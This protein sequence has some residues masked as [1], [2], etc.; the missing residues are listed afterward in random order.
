MI[1]LTRDAPDLPKED[2]LKLKKAFQRV[3]DRW[4][5]INPKDLFDIKLGQIWNLEVRLMLECQ[6]MNRGFYVVSDEA[7]FHATKIKYPDAL[8][9][10]LLQ[11]YR[12]WNGL[13]DETYTMTV[14]PKVMMIMSSMP[15][16]KVTDTFLS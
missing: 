13:L 10:H 7:D 8:V 3:N 12:L 1:K 14:L 9:I 5:P 6:Y 16:I 2:E 15:G 4:I 11:L